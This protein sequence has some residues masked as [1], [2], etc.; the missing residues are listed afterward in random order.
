MMHKLPHKR[1]DLCMKIDEG[2]DFR[3]HL[4]FRDQSGG[5]LALA[6]QSEQT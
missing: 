3:E 2:R 5:R 6:D 4:N 1:G